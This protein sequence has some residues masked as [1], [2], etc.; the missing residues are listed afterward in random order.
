MLFVS[1]SNFLIKIKQKNSNITLAKLC[2]KRWECIYVR[3][4]TRGIYQARHISTLDLL[5]ALTLDCI[6]IA[7]ADILPA[8]VGSDLSVNIEDDDDDAVYSYDA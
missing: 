3:K 1:Q 5:W 7:A 4:L 2:N 8:S 6:H